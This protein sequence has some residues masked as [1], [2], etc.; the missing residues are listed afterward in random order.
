MYPFPRMLEWETDEIAG[1][2]FSRIAYE[3][4]VLSKYWFLKWL[5]I[6]RNLRAAQIMDISELRPTWI[7]LSEK[8]EI[9]LDDLIQWLSTKPYWACFYIQRQ[10]SRRDLEALSRL[11][12]RLDVVLAVSHPRL[13]LRICPTCLLQD[14][15]G[16]AG[17][18]IARRSHQLP[19]SLVCHKHGVRLIHKC[20]GCD[21]VL[22]PRANLLRVTSQCENCGFDLTQHSEPPLSCLSPIRK[23]AVFEHDCLYSSYAPRPA[24]EIVA[25]IRRVCR[26]RNTDLAKVV[27]RMFGPILSTWH[28]STANPAPS[29]LFL[30]Q[31]TM[32][33]LCACL[34]AL[35]FSHESAQQAIVQ[36]GPIS[37]APERSLHKIESISQAREIVSG[38]IPSTKRRRLSWHRMHRRSRFL[39]WF[40]VLK[41]RAWL[42]RQLAPRQRSVLR[43]PCVSEDR[44]V[45]LGSGSYDQRREA[46]ARAYY[47]DREWM[48]DSRRNRKV[49]RGKQ[50]TAARDAELTNSIRTAMADW[51]A[52]PGRPVKFTLERAAA[53]VGV[54][55]SKILNLNRR[56]PQTRDTL[57]ESTTH[58]RLRVLLWLMKQ[59]TAQGVLLTPGQLFKQARVAPTWERRHFWAATVVYLFGPKGSYS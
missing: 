59:K 40:L 6:S 51:F 38:M 53:L 20:P 46:C 45:I 36:L 43:I 8:L 9:S 41:D 29:R 28:R 25:F 42:E 30:D 47:R 31:E 49:D 57:Y 10:L 23:L 39:F 14:L 32:P 4:A 37:N 58:Y 22:I 35:G 11:P 15:G 19:G 12:I 26:E 5:G 17:V 55:E 52:K 7:G 16:A 50:L 2:Y 54:N 33:T 3:N 34:V 21:R 27:L 44:Q 24:R 13:H 18:P 56:A 48:H 1:S